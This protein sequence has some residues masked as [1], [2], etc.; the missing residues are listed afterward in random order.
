VTS[1][2]FLEPKNQICDVQDLTTFFSATC[3][4]LFW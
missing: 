2:T 3:R 4:G 1:L